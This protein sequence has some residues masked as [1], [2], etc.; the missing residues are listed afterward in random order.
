MVDGRAWSVPCS[1]LVVNVP[2]HMLVYVQGDLPGGGGS[3][4]R[5]A[6]GRVSCHPHDAGGRVI[7]RS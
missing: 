6:G 7:P 4:V 2:V 5:V 3:A 1:D